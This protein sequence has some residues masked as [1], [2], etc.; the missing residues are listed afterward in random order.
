[1]RHTAFA[2]ARDRPAAARTAAPPSGLVA[3]SSARSG[4]VARA[5]LKSGG[6]GRYVRPVEDKSPM[7]DEE[8][9][10]DPADLDDDD[11]ASFDFDDEDDEEDDD[12]RPFTR[13]EIV[14]KTLR[15]LEAREK[16]KAETREKQLTKL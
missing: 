16:Q 7:K 2:R 14:K 3:W 10:F 1:M 13:G 12:E 11:D 9:Y 6:E 15:G 8:I 4:V 5:E